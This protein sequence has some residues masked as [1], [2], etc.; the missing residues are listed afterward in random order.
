MYKGGYS[1]QGMGVTNMP[2]KYLRKKR[3]KMQNINIYMKLNCT[4]LFNH[5][6][7]LY[8]LMLDLPLKP[9]GL[10]GPVCRPT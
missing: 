3:N 8:R 5:A 4:T 2:V 1:L 9:M 10:D 6:K 7:L